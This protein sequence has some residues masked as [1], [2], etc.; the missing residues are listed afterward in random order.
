[1]YGIQQVGRIAHYALVKHLE[2]YG[3]HPLRKTPGPWSHGITP[4]N[5]TLIVDDFGVKY[6]VKN[7]ALHLKTAL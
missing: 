3:Y 7:P 2:P 1:M 4:I 6:L 5:F